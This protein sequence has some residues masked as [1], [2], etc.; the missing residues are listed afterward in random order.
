LGRFSDLLVEMWGG[1]DIIVDPYT[2]AKKTVIAITAPQMVDV[3]VRH[4][5]SFNVVTLTSQP[6]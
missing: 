5:Q 6:D 4:P 3:N 1:T 2:N